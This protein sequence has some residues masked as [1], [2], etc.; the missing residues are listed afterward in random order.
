MARSKSYGYPLCGALRP[1]NA[2]GSPVVK[3]QTL[4][5]GEGGLLFGKGTE[6]A[7]ALRR[8]LSRIMSTGT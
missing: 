8:A 1:R 3:K 2:P 7:P 4:P 5:G 6:T